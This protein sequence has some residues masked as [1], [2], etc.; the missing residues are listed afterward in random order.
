MTTSTAFRC[1]L[2]NEL[3]VLRTQID[4]TINYFD[5]PIVI[6]CP[7]CGNEMRSTL[8]SKGFAQNTPFTIDNNLHDEIRSGTVKGKTMAYSN[9]LPTPVSLY[10]AEYMLGNFS[11]FLTLSQIFGKMDYHS[12]HNRILGQFLNNYFSRKESLRH[13]LP[14]LKNQPFSG[15]AFEKIWL[16]EWGEDIT[17]TA[18]CSQ[19]RALECYKK[20]IAE[21]H[22][23]LA[24]FSVRKRSK[25]LKNL[26]SKKEALKGSPQML[27][28]EQ[29]LS[30]FFDIEQWKLEVIDCISDWLTQVQRYFPAMLLSNTGHIDN[31]EAYELFI[32]TIG[33]KEAENYYRQSFDLLTKAIP[34]LWGLQNLV[35]NGNCD[36]F[37]QEP[38][39]TLA[40]F[41]TLS[42]GAK[43]EAMEKNAQLMGFLQPGLEN[44]I[45]NGLGHSHTTYSPVDQTIECHYNASDP[46]KIYKVKLYTLC[47][48]TYLNMMRLM[49]LVSI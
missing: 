21:F 28:F 11:I 37:K 9:T 14:I 7:S 22:D 31:A 34:W 35:E 5:W 13:V 15:K 41:A 1:P 48:Y 10:Y 20:A 17:S 18:G 38:R 42:E 26:F 46:Q 33:V 39:M 45:R 25:F 49:E 30:S 23:S 29:M 36:C 2:C 16:T 27:P 44:R 3:L 8:T 40:R 6:G 12:E 32:L 47:H 19:E 43:L 4:T 24:A